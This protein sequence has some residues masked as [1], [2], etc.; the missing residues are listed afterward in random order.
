M[1]HNLRLL[2]LDSTEQTPLLHGNQNS[3]SFLTVAVQSTPWD[4]RCHG[5]EASQRCGAAFFFLKYVDKGL[6]G[7]DLNINNVFPKNS[8]CQ[9]ICSILTGAFFPSCGTPSCPRVQTSF[10]RFRVIAWFSFPEILKYVRC[11][12]ARYLKSALLAFKVLCYP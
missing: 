12:S 2:D 6:Y 4:P 10:S 3:C 1:W 8:S 7:T 5:G 9:N 11:P